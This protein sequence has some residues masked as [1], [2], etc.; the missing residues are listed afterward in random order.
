MD[1]FSLS[2]G[3]LALCG[4]IA[5]AETRIRKLYVSLRGASKEMDDMTSQLRELR[6]ILDILRNDGP[7]EDSTRVAI[8]SEAENRVFDHIN[9]CLTAIQ[10]LEDLIQG[11][12]GERAPGVLWALT[13]KSK[14]ISLTKTLRLHKDHLKWSINVF[15][16]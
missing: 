15:T 8:P 11:I 4:A 7:Q 2:V 5:S 13:A 14:V 6:Q 10:D 9:K 3:C 16:G 1:P 12:Q